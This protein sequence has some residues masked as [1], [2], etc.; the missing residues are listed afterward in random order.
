M[1]TTLLLT[2]VILCIIVFVYRLVQ[3]LNSADKTVNEA[4]QP[5]STIPYK[6]LDLHTTSVADRQRAYRRSFHKQLQYDELQRQAEALNDIRTL[7]SI[8]TNTYEGNLPILRPDGYTHYTSEDYE[9][10]IAGMMYRNLKQV[11]KCEGLSDARLVAEPTNEFD[12]MQ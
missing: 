1:I 8:R 12:P 5:Q 7:E 4:P 10:D 9:I 3:S 2:V 11:K 6:L